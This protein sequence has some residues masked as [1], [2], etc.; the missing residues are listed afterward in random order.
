MVRNVKLHQRRIKEYYKEK[1]RLTNKQFRDECDNKDC[2]KTDPVALPLK[3]F[4]DYIEK[5]KGA[6]EGD[7]YFSS[8]SIMCR[9]CGYIFA[10]G[11]RR[12]LVHR[13]TRSDE[14]IIDELLY[15]ER[16]FEH[17]LEMMTIKARIKARFIWEHLVREKPIPKDYYK[18]TIQKSRRIARE[19][20]RLNSLCL[21]QNKRTKEEIFAG[22]RLR[23]SIKNKRRVFNKKKPAQFCEAIEKGE[24]KE[25][26]VYGHTSKIKF[27]AW[28][29]NL[30]IIYFPEDLEDAN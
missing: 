18:P 2:A 30:K 28:P 9:N 12:E 17:Y 4:Y 1:N 27:Q 20:L 10:S 11:I 29:T 22:Q 16:R 24:G 15:L 23:Y 8:C 13:E 14:D 26:I 25:I 3:R 6:K 19:N 7:F 5:P 21:Y